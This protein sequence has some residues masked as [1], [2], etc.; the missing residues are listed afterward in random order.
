MKTGF[1][2]RCFSSREGRK[3]LALLL[4][5]SGGWSGSTALHANPWQEAAAKDAVATVVVYNLSDQVGKELADFYCDARHIDPTHEIGLTAPLSEEISRS[6]YQKSIEGP[7]VEEFVKRGYWQFARSPSGKIR[8]VASQ[9]RFVVLIKGIPLKIAPFAP[10][11]SPT[12]SQQSIP[13]SS[14][15]GSP[16]SVQGSVLPS[17][18]SS[19]SAPAPPVYATCNAASVDSEL[20]MMG[21]FHHP[22][23]GPL[24]SPYCI[25]G[26]EDMGDSASTPDPESSATVLEKSRIA[27]GYLMVARLDGPTV[28]C[29]RSMVLNG[30]QVE[31]EGLWGW[32][33]ADLRSITEGTYRLGDDWIRTAAE[34]MR[35]SG[36][37]VLCDDLPET[38]PQGFPLPEVSAYYGWYSGSIDGPFADAGF[39]FQPGA[40][41][42]HLHS[43]SASSLR[44]PKQG[45][46]APLL[47]HGAAASLGNVYEPYLGFTTNLGILARMLLAGHTLVESY[48]TAQPVLSW[49]SV[50]VGDPLY[51]PYARLAEAGLKETSGLPETKWTDYYRI[52]LAHKGSVLDASADLTRRAQ[53]KH[54]SLYLEA[55][56]AAQYDAGDW[57]RA[58]G[59]F[60]VATALTKDPAT[61][62]RLLLEQ[63]RALEK[64]G[65]KIRSIA[66]LAQELNH[67]HSIAEQ[68][69]LLTWM[70]RIDPKSCPVLR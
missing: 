68:K 60:R 61:S 54:E 49:M 64:L 28:E 58:E 50:L 7:L 10:S 2:L 42:F 51:R 39:H 32:G 1:S 18:P 45:W 38:I 66:L 26:R 8:M 40:V 48:Y 12:P 62:F 30:I 23:L 19:S 31:K 35:R 53:E 15:N 65:D 70:S 17:Q 16:S 55:L 44:D 5:L 22:V 59:S 25:K 69:L 67:E 37:P 4:F 33:I 56:G 34:A 9:V 57:A 21:C 6:D 43:F 47:L 27:L 11:I 63:V 52:I 24:G 20:S 41:A 46:T 13:Q 36:I 14:P 3:V 29:V